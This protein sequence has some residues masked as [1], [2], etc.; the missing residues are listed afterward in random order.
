MNDLKKIRTEFEKPLKYKISEWRSKSAR[1]HVEKRKRPVAY[2]TNAELET[3]T[4]LG[5]K[6]NL[7][8]IAEMSNKNMI[9]LSDTEKQVIEV[10]IS[11]GKI[12]VSYD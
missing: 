8:Q 9:L 3:L 10:L 11:Y 6:F 1:Y 4:M 2:S 12:S 7:I 5:R